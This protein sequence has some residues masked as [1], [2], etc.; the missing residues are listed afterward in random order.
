MKT[1]KE[2]LKKLICFNPQNNV[3]CLDYIPVVTN[4]Y[5]YLKDCIKAYEKYHKT[6]QLKA[7]STLESSISTKEESSESQPSPPLNQERYRN[8]SLSQGKK[9][10]ATS[11]TTSNKSTKQRA[12][13]LSGKHCKRYVDNFKMVRLWIRKSTFLVCNVQHFSS[14]GM[15]V[16]ITA[17][18]EV[19]ERKFGTDDW[20]IEYKCTNCK[21]DCNNVYVVIGERDMKKEDS[22]IFC[23][24]NCSIDHMQLTGAGVW[25]KWTKSKIAEPSNSQDVV[26][27]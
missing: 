16:E 1:R 25:E 23:S 9:N 22:M 14:T 21:K 15:L 26:D 11:S 7:Y 13:I 19:E 8:R 3:F 6:N 17:F 20:D 2:S 4:I 27:E 24:S 18:I 12:C 5:F 10:S